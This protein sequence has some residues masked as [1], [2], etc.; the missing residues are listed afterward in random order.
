M[1]EHE[2]T[3]ANPDRKLR[4]VQEARA[5]DA[6]ASLAL[7][8]PRSGCEGRPIIRTLSRWGSPSYWGESY[9]AQQNEVNRPLDLSLHHARLTGESLQSQG[10]FSQRIH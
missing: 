9:A 10:F 7:V 1:F 5:D 4:F 3:V 8:L 6:A 2:E